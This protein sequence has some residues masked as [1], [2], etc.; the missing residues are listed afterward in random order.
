MQKTKGYLIFLPA[1][2]YTYK[3]FAEGRVTSNQFMSV[4]RSSTKNA[5][6]ILYLY[7]NLLFTGVN[8]RRAFLLKPAH[9]VTY[10]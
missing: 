2:V 6:R 1:E 5:E 3:A 4:A 7:C 9:R 8:K 10:C